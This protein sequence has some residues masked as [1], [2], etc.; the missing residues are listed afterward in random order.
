M[1]G[2]LPVESAHDDELV[3]DDLGVMG[4]CG[5]QVAPE[6]EDIKGMHGTTEQEDIK[7]L[8]GT[9]VKGM[10]MVKSRVIDKQGVTPVEQEQIAASAARVTILPR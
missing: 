9:T 4:R 8:N 1:T 10:G 2:S 3:G 7:D 5:D 6:Q